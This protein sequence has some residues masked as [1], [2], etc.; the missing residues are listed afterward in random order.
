MKAQTPLPPITDGMEGKGMEVLAT[1][2]ASQTPAVEETRI[3]FCGRYW[4]VSVANSEQLPLCPICYEGIANRLVCRDFRHA[5]CAECRP[6]MLQRF[7]SCQTCR[8]V[9]NRTGESEALEQELQ[10]SQRAVLEAVVA[11]CVDCQLWS[12]PLADV[13]QHTSSCAPSMAACRWQLDGCDWHGLQD[14][15]ASHEAAC[16]WQLVTCTLPG[17]D[18]RIPLWRKEG[19]EERCG[20]RQLAFGG[21]EIA[22]RQLHDFNQ[23]YRQCE[24]DSLLR[25]GPGAEQRREEALVSLMEAFRL[26]YDAARAAQPP[27]PAVRL[28]ECRW[29]CDYRASMEQMSDHYAEC[30]R[31]EIQ[32]SFCRTKV[33]RSG[34]A[35]H[36]AQCEDRPVDCPRDCGQPGLRARDIAPTGSH[37]KE[38]RRRISCEDCHQTLFAVEDVWESVASCA[39]EK[40]KPLCTAHP[41]RCDWC[42]GCHP[43]PQFQ[44]QS[45]LCRQRLAPLCMYVWRLP[46]GVDLVPDQKAQGPVYIAREGGDQTVFVQLTTRALVAEAKRQDCAKNMTPHLRFSFN[47][48][49][50]SLEL[51]CD[52]WGR[53]NFIL[54]TD[55]ASR[56]QVSLAA[57]LRRD[58]GT[59]LEKLGQGGSC[60]EATAWPS[61]AAASRYAAPMAR[62]SLNIALKNGCTGTTRLDSLSDAIGKRWPPS[63]FFLHLDARGWYD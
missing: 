8:A 56:P 35:W 32:C 58:D 43:R 22:A 31:L 2:S 14:D 53:F 30:P 59:L 63:A 34:L 40:H 17:C 26:S 45:E 44:Q 60:S 61:M 39:L 24:D 37:T 13:E 51:S 21:T 49:P 57:Y 33:R 3:R 50:C 6:E 38:C 28:S 29:G 1:P 47:G 4:T 18:R 9:L 36:M 48:M 15:Q 52:Q 5:V 12:G 41:V 10:K 54:K 27:R 25:E 11:R 20:D 19:H 42:F 46:N 55:S 62:S 23:L 16:R 7:R